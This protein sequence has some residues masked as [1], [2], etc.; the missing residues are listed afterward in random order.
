MFRVG[1]L[2]DPTDSPCGVRH[3]K[4]R[5]R[6]DIA[7]IGFPD[8][9]EEKAADHTNHAQIYRKLAEVWLASFFSTIGYQ[10][11]DAESCAAKVEKV[12]EQIA[13][14]DIV[15]AVIAFI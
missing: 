2:H 10:S 4:Q 14:A 1:K 6:K 7:G 15:T 13:E 3:E 9:V 12:L 11:A 5:I 8:H